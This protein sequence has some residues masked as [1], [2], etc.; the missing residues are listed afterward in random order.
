MSDLSSGLLLAAGTAF[1]L[2]VLTSISP[3][4]LASNI[5]A[6][7]YIGGGMS[8]PRR[9]MIAGLLYT[10]GR[11]LTYAV[12]GW[13]LVTSL[14]SAV[15]LSDALQRVMNQLLG[16]ALILAGMFLLDLLRWSPRSPNVAGGIQR[17]AGASGLWGAVVIGGLFALSFCPVSAALFFGSLIPLAAGNGNSVLLASVYGVGTGLPVLAV[18]ILFVLGAEA[19]SSAFRRMTS[20]EVWARPV[21][22]L[23]FVL[24]GAYYTLNYVFELLG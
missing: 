7:S 14:A 23:V 4:P 21:T 11:V 5:A 12:L 16:P 6:I 20:I 3:C 24:I 2:G 9:M 8:H 10:L 22:G 19:M 18:S 17:L 1:W 15:R 13:L